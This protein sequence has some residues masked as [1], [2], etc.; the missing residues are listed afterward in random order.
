MGLASLGLLQSDDTLTCAAMAELEKYTDNKEYVQD[1]IF[2]K[3][4]QTALKVSV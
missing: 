1:V 4:M 3:A 2:L